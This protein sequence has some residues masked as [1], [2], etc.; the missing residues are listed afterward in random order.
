MTNPTL[1]FHLYVVIQF[2][3]FWRLM[4]NWLIL[5]EGVTRKCPLSVKTSAP[6]GR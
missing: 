6:P 1:T 2:P 3:R 5:L 4:P